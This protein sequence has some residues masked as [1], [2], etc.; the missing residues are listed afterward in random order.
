[1]V[2]WRILLWAVLVLAALLFLYLVRGILL[3]FILSYVIA[4]LLDPTVRKLRLRGYSRK[5]AV[6]LV[7][8]VFF[9]GLV[10]VGILAAPQI[11]TQVANLNNKVTDVTA[12]IMRVNAENNFF[13]R[14]NPVV[15]AR[16]A[17][18][19]NQLDQ[20]LGRYEGL[21]GRMGLPTNTQEILDQY[22]EPQRGQIAQAVRT[23]F[24]SFFGILVN[25]S[26]Q[27]LTIVLLP[28]LVYLILVDM[29]D[30]K[31]RSPRWIPP[32]IR[33]STVA[34]LGDIGQVFVKYLRGVT[35][36]VVLYIA[37]GL[38]LLLLLN[39]PFAI[40]LAVIFGALY[41]IPY[42]GNIINYVILFLMIGVNGISGTFFMG[43]GS[44]WVYAAIVTVLF[45][46]FGFIFDHFVYPQMVGNSVGLNAVVS[47][48]V[49]FCGAALF[50]LPGM[51]LAFPFAGSVK[52]ILDR[53]IRVT[54]TTGEQLNL[55]SVPMRHRANGTG[56]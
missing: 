46:T 33:S 9:L 44:P 13:V 7:M 21:L 54:S 30:F 41:L 6:V 10:L 43:F 14:W 11:T 53:L 52:V 37:I 16:R 45:A 18:G 4:V 35:M 2:G 47:L 39:V 36:V 32:S 40:L 56:A 15:Q 22:V 51:I 55:P 26:S 38:V 1:M 34:L 31:R 12:S 50:G 48:F 28:F 49:I 23:G 19:G 17:G 5:K 8:T 42:I 27:L 24:Q 25:L 20:F 29:E 3:P